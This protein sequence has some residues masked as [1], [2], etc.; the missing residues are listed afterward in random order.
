MGDSAD[1]IPGVPGVGAGKAQK[2][3][4]HFGCLDGLISA[5]QLPEDPLPEGNLP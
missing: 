4:S 1:N 2:L 5:L 3:I